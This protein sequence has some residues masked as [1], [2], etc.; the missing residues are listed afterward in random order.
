M[1]CTECG[2]PGYSR[3]TKTPEWRCRS[4]SCGYEWDATTLPPE[5]V[6]PEE[7][8]EQLEAFRRDADRRAEEHRLQE[9]FDGWGAGLAF[10]GFFIGLVVGR[11]LSDSA[12]GS[13]LG[14]VLIGLI[15]YV[16]GK[17][18]CDWTS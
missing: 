6:P 3:K 9:K 18:W 2:A 4:R 14:G 1:R 17:N 12:Q 16:V 11:A 8:M 7:L 10:L 13:L 5:E 15:G